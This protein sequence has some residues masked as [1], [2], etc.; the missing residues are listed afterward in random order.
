MLGNLLIELLPEM[1]KNNIKMVQL[2]NDLQIEKSLYGKIAY[3]RTG[4]TIV[5]LDQRNTS[6]KLTTK[7]L[8][9]H[10]K[11]KIDRWRSR[12]N[13]C[14]GYDDGKIFLFG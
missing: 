4:L 1:N 2:E 11:K 13:M 5:K 7:Y 9:P 3:V 10:F 14:K 12:W 6:L 8:P